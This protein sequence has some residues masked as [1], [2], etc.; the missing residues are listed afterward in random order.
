[1][2]VFRLLLV[3]NGFGMMEGYLAYVGAANAHIMM[4]LQAFA[5]TLKGTLRAKINDQTLQMTTVTVGG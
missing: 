1:M 2:A 3:L 4:E 5:R